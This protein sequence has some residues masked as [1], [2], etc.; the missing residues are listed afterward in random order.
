ML[1]YTLFDIDNFLER[2]CA[3]NSGDIFK[4]N[5]VYV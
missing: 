3:E 4:N 2:E 1:K 5:F